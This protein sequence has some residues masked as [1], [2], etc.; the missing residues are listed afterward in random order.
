MINLE[1]EAKKYKR[2]ERLSYIFGIAAPTFAAAVIA[3]NKFPI[4]NELYQFSLAVLISL[5]PFLYL[6]FLLV[7]LYGKWLMRNNSPIVWRALQVQIN[8]LQKIAFPKHV[9][10]INDNHRVTLFKFTRTCKSKRAKLYK[11]RCTKNSGW[12]IPV[13]RS[14]NTGKETNAK[15]FAPDSGIDAEGI[16]GMCWSSQHVQFRENLPNIIKASAPRTKQKYCH[17]SNMPEN[18]LDEYVDNGR[19]VARS[20]LAYPVWSRKGD[21]WGVLVFDSIEPYGVNE[22]E[23][24]QAFNTVVETL[25]VLVEDVK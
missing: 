16:V 13:I 11:K 22:Q 17:R 4:T 6:I 24:E 15:F 8:K 19:T 5:S 14:G 21:S 18:I 23:A 1:N 20:I 10:D 25:G 3:L 7:F 9:G 12:L 2:G